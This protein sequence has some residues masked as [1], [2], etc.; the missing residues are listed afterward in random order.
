[1]LALVSGKQKTGTRKDEERNIRP[2]GAIASRN[3]LSQS[4]GGIMSAQILSKDDF[5]LGASLLSQLLKKVDIKVKG[6]VVEMTQIFELPT[7][8][9]AKR[10]AETL[11]RQFRGE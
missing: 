3:C 7:P 2:E 11:A 9:V 5:Q 10:F 4:G 6:N 1:L 8:E